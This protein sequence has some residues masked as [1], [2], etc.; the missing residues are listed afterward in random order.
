[1]LKS[2]IKAQKDE[3][4]DPTHDDDEKMAKIKALSAEAEEDNNAVKRILSQVKGKSKDEDEIES[5]AT[6]GMT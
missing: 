4:T 3:L 5:E 1:L 6:K 2:S